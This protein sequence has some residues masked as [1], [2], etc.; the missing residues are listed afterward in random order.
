MKWTNINFK[1]FSFGTV[2][3]MSAFMPNVFGQSIKYDT[4]VL[5][6][7]LN[8]ANAQYTRAV[9]EQLPLY[10][11]PEYYFYNP[12]KI[13]GSAYFMEMGY[14]IGDVYYDGAEYR[15]IQLLYDIYKDQLVSLLY[16][17]NTKYVL[18]NDGVRN[19]DLLGHHFININADTLPAKSV[20]KTGYYELLYRG[21]TEGLSKRYKEIQVYQ[22][23]SGVLEAYNYFTDTKEDFFIRKDKTYYKITSQGVLLDILKDRKKQLQQYIRANKIKFNKDPGRALSSIA[24][25]YDTITN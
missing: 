4:T 1:L 22:S 10:N 3:L 24:G 25:Y 6:A 2:V 21:K 14:T 12:L 11:G 23:S 13:K 7:A 8:N 16:D 15:G 20:M 9:D 5:Q 17:Q 19:F 18:L